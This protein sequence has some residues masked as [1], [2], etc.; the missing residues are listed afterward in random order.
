MRFVSWF[1]P[2]AAFL[3]A[4]L[5]CGTPPGS[6]GNLAAA[7]VTLWSIGIDESPLLPDYQPTDEFG[8]E[9]WINDARPGVVSLWPDDPA[10]NE[11]TNPPRDD[12]FYTPGTY[13][14]GFNGLGTTRAVPRG[15]PDSAWETALTNHDRT[16][17]IHFVL[18][19]TSAGTNSRL[20]LS[21]ELIWSGYWIDALARPGYG[22][23]TNDI[24]VVFR[25]AT[26]RST[27]IFAGAVTADQRIDV[28]FAATAVGAS[29]G[30]NSIEI[31]RTGPNTTGVTSGL[32][33]D[34]VR[35]DVD[36]EAL[37]D[38][39]RDGMPFWWELDN[40]LSDADASD[41]V[42]DPDLDGR[43]NLAEFQRT[44]GST[45]P[46][47]ADTDS[48]GLDDGREE[49]LGTDPLNP[50][51]D[52]DGIRDGAEIAGS[53]SS[54]PLRLDTDGDGTPDAAE[55]RLGTLPA[56]ATST[57]R[58]FRG[59]IGFRVLFAEEPGTT[60]R[61]NEVA[62]VVP[63]PFWN[64]TRPIT[65]WQTTTGTLS[66]VLYP[67]PGRLVRSDGAPVDGLAIRW[68]AASAYSSHN[69]GS[70]DQRLMSGY[71]RGEDGNPLTLTVEGV[72]FARYDLY[73]IVGGAEPG[74]RG[75]LT[76]SSQGGLNTFEAA[77]S[78]PIH[79]FQELQPGE[80]EY[81]SGSYLRF[82]GQTARSF[83]LN[84]DG[85]EWWAV[86]IH[87]IQ[88]VDAD[89]DDDLS[90]IPDWFEHQHALQPASAELARADADADGL[91]NLAE[92]QAGTDPR[93]TDSDSDGLTDSD[94][95]R[96]GT[97]PLRADSDGDH[98]SDRAELALVVPTDPTR[99]DSDGDG[100]EDRAEIRPFGAGAG[101]VQALP[102][103]VYSNSP[104]RWD[105]TVDNLQLVWDHR[106]GDLDRGPWNDTTFLA[107][108]VRNPE[109]SNWRVLG[110]DLRTD[111]DALIHLITSDPT[112]AFSGPD[113]PGSFISE[114]DYGLVPEDLAPALGFSGFGASD[115]SD[116]L[117][118][119]VLAERNAANR[120]D[121]SFELR[122][123]TRNQPV[124]TR[125][126]PNCSAAPTVHS[127]LATWT[128]YQDRTNR[129]DLQL[130]RGLRAFISSTPLESLP[131]FAGTRDSDDDGIPDAWE[132]AHG[133]DRL[134]PADALGDPDADGLR[135][136]DEF[137][138]GSDPFRPDSDGD[139][140]RDGIEFA[141]LSNPAD[142]ASVPPQFGTRWPTGLDLD[143]NGLGDLWEAR[144]GARGLRAGDDSDAD[145][146]TNA[147]EA[148]WGTDPWSAGSRPEVRLEP[149]GT[150][151]RLSWT[152]V[153]SK[154]QLPLT[155]TNLQLWSTL[156]PA[157][158]PNPSPGSLWLPRDPSTDAAFFRIDVAALDSDGDGVPD[159]DEAVLGSDPMR[160]D[161]LHSPIL[162]ITRTG[163]VTGIVSGDLVAA[164]E[165]LGGGGSS[166]S[167][168]TRLAAVRLLQQATFGPT[169]AEID[170]VLRMG[171]DAWVEDQLSQPPTYHLPY[172]QA[173]TGDITGPRVDLSYSHDPDG[174][175]IHG[176][177]VTTPFART[178]LAAP[179]QLR[180]RVA[181][182]LS[183]ILVISRRDPNLE[184]RALA[185]SSYFDLLVRHAFGNYGE[186]LHDV[187]FHPAMG[188]Y[189][190]HLGNQKARP[191]INQ[192]P[193][194]NYAREI[195]QLFSIGLWE[196]HP[197]GTRRLDSRGDPIPTY[198]NAQITEFARVFTGF[199]FTGRVWG[200]GGWTDLE[201]TVPL[202]LNPERH[203]FGPKQLLRGRLIPE[204][205]PTRENALRDV[206][207]AIA[208]LVEHPNT[209]PFISRQLIQ[210]LV[211]SNPSTNY[212]AR[213]S[214]RFANDGAGRRGNLGAVVRAVLLDPEARADQG[215]GASPRFGRLKD[216]ALRF[217]AVARLGDVGRH[218]DLVWWTWGEFLQ[219]TRQEPLFAPSV[220]NF[221]RPD[222]SPPGL[223][224]EQQLAGPA[225]Q[226]TDS[227][228]AISLP[229]R[230][231]DVVQ[232][233]I[234][235]Y[236]DYSFPPDYGGLLAAAQRPE[237]LVDELN[238]LVCS[239]SMT[240]RTRDAM[241]S[242][243]N[244][245]PADDPIVRVHVAVY[246]AATSPEGAVQR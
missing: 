187:T 83:S 99:A 57:P 215:V 156:E 134:A 82:R 119:R 113:D 107:L 133:L 67:L 104:A 162:A 235:R 188:R 160:S 138:A 60:L 193:D 228:S 136:R 8:S 51:S 68:S 147:E 94:E 86:G 182:A 22:I 31:I 226:I 161:S 75:E 13:P 49:S 190:S 195:Q 111:G 206:D 97:N 14:A 242:A 201:N 10:Y 5:A 196:L 194:E 37:R 28:P 141:A 211:T 116:R 80:T 122:N 6:S 25:N 151:L 73:V 142:R 218:A 221:Y 179:D 132:D 69:T 85:P 79:E 208:N 212:V 130:Q 102:V 100:F 126:Y 17:R 230:L 238:L 29:A 120:W 197:D 89:R 45:N 95:L 237:Q 42:L 172:L 93:N 112:G 7:S 34:F 178:A 56:L 27:Q 236:T 15:E 72:P 105:W 92:F 222:Y 91:S 173:I 198:G 207:D 217:L 176:N 220:F 159:W 185:V 48:D 103:P 54:D 24:V 117:R 202:D 205:L 225:F 203:D 135:N 231:W 224:T 166:A 229:N 152:H 109:S 11:N 76:L 81:P 41:A 114:S 127:G 58:P 12:D 144:Y 38:A 64:E 210:F 145:G 90:G 33:F 87:A 168:V 216:P 154:T 245:I 167:P 170:R 150:G 158:D 118:F 191:E 139:G 183:Q 209:A 121:V 171:I 4:W 108:S 101:S 153:P 200:S 63:Q 213:V 199:W 78:L 66:E 52:G 40:G 244:Q 65:S 184:G 189:L 44:R 53:P 3:L 233:G 74:Y 46:R 131:A 240:R 214:A 128:D 43:S 181:F 192:Y 98:L 148:L 106:V 115:I 30:P 2:F 88:I 47:S 234:S 137:L 246:L 227:N 157:T 23:A 163:N 175:F 140:V 164:V 165:R 232:N 124:L 77:T 129:A 55:L 18:D 62:G 243:L 71:L 110:F 223:L 155:S 239:G 16:N 26:G 59:A 149:D 169:R 123:L 186:L 125:R 21:L 146:S 219:D 39:D 143:G 180:Q 36:T 241:L 1:R 70:P 96:R 61:S 9:N 20:H 174:G 35:L 32:Q 204:R 19:P 50:D 177:N 84:L